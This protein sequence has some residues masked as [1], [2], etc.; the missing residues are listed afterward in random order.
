[1]N[2]LLV[3]NWSKLSWC[4]TL[5]C[6]YVWDKIFVEW[7]KI[8]QNK[9][10]LHQNKERILPN[11][12]YKAVF[13]IR[14]PALCLPTTQSEKTQKAEKTQGVTRK[15]GMQTSTYGNWIFQLRNSFSASHLFFNSFPCFQLKSLI[16]TSCT[17]SEP[18]L[19]VSLFALT[20][21]FS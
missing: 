18:I 11:L 1:M 15:Q 5:R 14:R 4:F 10:S 20:K 9:L 12:K 13:P 17:Y 21:L 19:W 6:T 3:C 7:C 8:G 16:I 2:E